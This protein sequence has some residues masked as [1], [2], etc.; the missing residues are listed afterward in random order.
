MIYLAT[1]LSS[2]TFPIKVSLEISFSTVTPKIV[3][4]TSKN[5]EA[6]IQPRIVALHIDVHSIVVW[7]LERSNK[8]D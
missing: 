7:T 8:I 2:F 5:Q 3:A 6:H 1:F 4:S